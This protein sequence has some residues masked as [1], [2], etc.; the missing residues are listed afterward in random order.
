M[1]PVEVW[2]EKSF[3]KGCRAVTTPPSDPYRISDP[4]FN[5]HEDAEWEKTDLYTNLYLVPWR[6]L[7]PILFRYR[8][9]HPE[10]SLE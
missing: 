3:K 7:C 6:R 10:K 2:R 5:S 4:L 9:A 8:P 1:G